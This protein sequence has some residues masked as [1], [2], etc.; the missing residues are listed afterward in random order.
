MQNSRTPLATA[1]KGPRLGPDPDL[2]N[3]LNSLRARFSLIHV[4]TR[5]ED[6]L[7]RWLFSK[8]SALGSPERKLKVWSV[9]SGLIEFD[10]Q[11]EAAADEGTR[12][13]GRALEQAFKEVRDLGPR[14]EDEGTIYVFR[15][16]HPFYRERDVVRRLRDIAREFRGTRSTLILVSPT[17][18]VPEDLEVE[19]E[20]CD[21]P[22][23]SPEVIGRSIYDDIVQQIRESNAR[24]RDPAS[25]RALDESPELREAVLRAASGLT[26]VEAE[27]ALAKAVVEGKGLT[28]K[29]VEVVN[30]EKKR[31]VRRIPGLEYIPVDEINMGSVGGFDRAKAWFEE[32]G[33]AFSAEAAEFGLEPPK[34]VLMLGFPG[35]GK[36][37]AVKAL[38]KQWNMPLLRLDMSAL[39][40]GVVGKS[41]ANLH[42]AL[43]VASSISPCLLWLDELEKAFAGAGSSW[44]GDSGVAKG[45]FGIFLTWLQEQKGC[46]VYGTA[47]DIRALPPELLRKG[48]FD[49]IFFVDFPTYEERV[50]ILRIHLTRRGR[51]PDA[52]QLEDV[53][54]EMPGFVGAEIEQ[55]VRDALYRAFHDK[56]RGRADDLTTA[57]LIE[58]ANSTVPLIHTMADQLKPLRQ[59]VEDGRAVRV[60]SA[61][62]EV[63]EVT[64]AAIVSRDDETPTL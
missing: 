12:A 62:D 13:P 38:A 20:V 64:L 57:H 51:N 24:Q 19:V 47:N 44:V 63:N 26:L 15:D 16:L 39:K 33:H 42:E 30:R 23:P 43:R 37:L 29:A 34:G 8:R 10:P 53:A 50:E 36:S 40:A 21:F 6:R 27:N 9:T 22:L 5:E 46:F 11:G 41:E 54:R 3:L 45:I 48:R 55:V 58:A 4:P 18:S 31:F 14:A 56:K 61:R 1:P 32:R 7:A 35:T 52:Y 59:F 28:W 17:L 49:E 60:S 2:M 25:H